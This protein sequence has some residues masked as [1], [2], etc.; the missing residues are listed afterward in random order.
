MDPYE[1]LGVAK[2]ATDAEIKKAYRKL[3][4]QFHPDKNEGD[5]K[6]EE[7]FKQIADA[8]S[9][10]SDPEKRKQYES[11]K[12]ANFD[13][14]DTF[15]FDD[16]IKNQFGTGGFRE[17]GSR[18]RR[19]QSKT[20]VT[21]PDTTHLDIVIDIQT[22]F[23]EAVVGKKLEFNFSRKKINYTGRT[24]AALSFTKEI[25]EKEISINLDLRKM[26]LHIKKD[27]KGY[28]TKVRIPKLGNEDVLSRKNIW[29]DIEQVPL[30]GDLYIN[31]DLQ[32]P[33]GIELED[34]N[35]IQRVEISLFQVLN[36]LEKVKIETIFN[37]KYE[38][39]INSPKTLNDLKFN[40]LG[41]GF[42]NEKGIIGSYLIRFDVICPNLSKLSKEEKAQF[43]TTLASI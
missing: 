41:E 1:I 20:T 7:K 23:A 27:E 38:A 5:K 15:S 10:L 17:H 6:A 36:H 3:A 21:Q 16:F 32:V 39:E 18:G 24:G 9:I 2:T 33:V 40:L 28:S 30:F 25:D 42:A 12:S 29:G 8:Y 34:G 4:V 14:R 35:I 37:K 26:G 31:I 13:W 11:S 22:Q 19:T 43:L